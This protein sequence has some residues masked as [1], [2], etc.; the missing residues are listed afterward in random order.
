MNQMENNSKN[1]IYLDHAATTRTDSRVLEEM[2]PYFNEE[3]GNPSAI[4]EFA[5]SNK[6]AVN[7]AR[8]KLAKLLNCDIREVYFTSG[9]TESDNHALV[10]T[11]ESRAGDGRHII[12]S[13]IEHHAVL[14]CCDYLKTRGYEITYLPV[15]E[16][17]LVSPEALQ[18]VIRSDTILVSVMM[19]NNEIGT[20]QPIHE[21]CQIA[22][23]YG[24]WFH[25]DAVQA[26]GQIPVDVKE[27]DVD[28]CS[29]SAHKMYGPKG[30]GA[31]YIKD[32]IKIGSFIHGGAQERHRRAGTENVPAIIGFG[33]AAELAME[34]MQEVSERESS[35]RDY[36]MERVL[37][38]IPYSRINGHRTMRL[39]GNTNFCFQFTEG[40]SLLI[41]LDMKGICASSGSA[42]STGSS[43]P[44]HVL[45][46]IGLPP[47]L[48]RGSLRLTLGAETTR[49]EIDYTIEQLKEIVTKV[50][51]MSQ[52]Y[53]ETIRRK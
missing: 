15:S 47:E 37:R 46:A 21:L 27:L 32:G 10:G 5:T 45:T 24:A 1:K 38:E 19:A 30:I 28:L 9:G 31:L 18:K 50:R 20:I 29:I 22:H 40:E 44:S 17:G 4:Y 2:L 41:L 6:R 34:R 48:A 39:P 13:Q 51:A 53:E 14:H 26:A 3:Y 16:N 11:A 43:E 23:Q 49:E 12:T 7:Q 8:G 25:T 33:K 36:L 42:C 35:L 52:E